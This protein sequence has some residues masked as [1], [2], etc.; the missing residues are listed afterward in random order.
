MMTR[1]GKAQSLE[2]LRK[3]GFTV[4]VFFVCDKSWSE[5]SVLEK[6]RTML[7][8]ARYFAVRSSADNEDS[9]GRSYAGHFY[10]GIGIA[11]EDV[12]FEMMKVQKS[13]GEMPGSI[14]VQDF[15]ESDIA[16]VM[17]S[18]VNKNTV[19][20][21]A[22]LGLCQTVVSGEACDEYICNKDGMLLEKAISK[23]KKVSRLING[24][25][26]SSESGY[27]SLDKSQ[28]TRLV[29]LAAEVQSFFSSPQDIEW[30]FKDNKLYL[31]QSRPI[32][33]D[34]RIGEEIYF[35]SAN[36]AEAIRA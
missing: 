12:Y 23:E 15:I 25:I 5:K 4:P 32:T 31:L 2:R 1:T 29:R 22:T 35:D 7:P 33:R 34:F 20:I 9:E 14:I 28:I 36:I 24:K 21:N 26:I 13:F 3:N 18:E 16:G 8:I 19:V 17:F 27:E 30:C 11:K 6:I 10:T